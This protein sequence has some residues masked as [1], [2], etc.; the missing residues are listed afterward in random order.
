MN[1]TY[2]LNSTTNVDVLK[3]AAGMAWRSL[4]QFASQGVKSKAMP[5]DTREMQHQAP[6]YR[7]SLGASVI[8][9]RYAHSLNLC[10]DVNQESLFST[11]TPTGNSTINVV[12]DCFLMFMLQGKMCRKSVDVT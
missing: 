11:E 6:R 9:R 3:E 7:H 10:L 12:F 5:W 1:L 8:L 2:A 4:S